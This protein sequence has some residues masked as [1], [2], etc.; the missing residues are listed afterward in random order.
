MEREVARKYG[1]S[2][3]K[4]RHEMKQL[5]RK[6]VRRRRCNVLGKKLTKISSKEIAKCVC[7]ESRKELGKKVRKKVALSY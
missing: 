3:A 4:S 6:K 1:K 2:I 7:K 5:T